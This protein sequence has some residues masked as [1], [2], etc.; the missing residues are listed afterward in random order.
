MSLSRKLTSRNND[1]LRPT[2]VLPFI[3][4]VNCRLSLTFRVSKVIPLVTIHLIDPLQCLYSLIG[5][6]LV[7]CKLH[8]QTTRAAVLVTAISSWRIFFI[9]SIDVMHSLLA[10]NERDRS[11]VLDNNIASS[12]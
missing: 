7:T 3:L 1:R 9:P 10:L 11:P 8:N 12:L 4:C 6:Q 5:R 2:N